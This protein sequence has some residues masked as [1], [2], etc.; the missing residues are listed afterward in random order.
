[1][2][3]TTT[4]TCPAWCRSDHEADAL[5]YPLDPAPV[6][7]QVLASLDDDFLVDIALDVDDDGA[8]RLYVWL[9]GESL[10]VPAGT[11]EQRAELADLFRNA[12]AGLAGVDR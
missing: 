4:T 10:S 11:A 3:T 12:A 1:M 2:T 7:R 5:R 8:A 9:G 6:H